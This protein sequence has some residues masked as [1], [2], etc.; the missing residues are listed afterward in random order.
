MKSGGRH[1]V[2]GDA[3]QLNPDEL[4]CSHI[5]RTAT[6]RR[7]LQRREKLVGRLD[8]QPADFRDDPKLVRSF[9][10]APSVAY[11]RDC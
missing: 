11:I 6:A 1:F 2:P 9:F 3:P 7:P 10:E 8:Q 4:V 5:K